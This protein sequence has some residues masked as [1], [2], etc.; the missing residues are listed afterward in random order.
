M[1]LNWELKIVRKYRDKLVLSD[2]LPF[3][4]DRNFDFQLE[5][6][7][8]GRSETLEAD[9]MSDLVLSCLQVEERILDLM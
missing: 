5:M 6:R 1:R 9:D 2:F 7:L 8:R 3:K 4:L